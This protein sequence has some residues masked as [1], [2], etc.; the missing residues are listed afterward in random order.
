MKKTA[1]LATVTLLALVACSSY[2]TQE[3]YV[4]C[5]QQREARGPTQFDDD[6]FASCVECHENC[7]QD[8][9]AAEGRESLTYECP[10]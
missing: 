4:A 5:D 7:G 6:A 8:C 3:A 2:S 9:Q 1:L 10:P